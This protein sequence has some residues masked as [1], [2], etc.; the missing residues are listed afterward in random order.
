MEESTVEG[1]K[2]RRPRVAME[3][4]QVACF[5]KTGS[6]R[7]KFQNLLN[8]IKT[9]VS[10]SGEEAQE[11]PFSPISNELEKG[12]GGLRLTVLRNLEMKTDG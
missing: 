6:I 3:A 11:I 12:R 5:R 9:A 8:K 1:S 4:K 2:S 10:V 7:H